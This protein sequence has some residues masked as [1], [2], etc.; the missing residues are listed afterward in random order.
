MYQDF[1]G[2]TNYFWVCGRNFECIYQSIL[3]IEYFLRM[4]TFFEALR[5]KRSAK[6]LSQQAVAKELG[7]SD[8]TYQN[9]ETDKIPPHESLIQLNQY[10]KHDFSRYIYQDTFGTEEKSPDDPLLKEL[11]ALVAKYSNVNSDDPRKKFQQALQSGRGRKRLPEERSRPSDD[12]LKVQGHLR[13]RGNKG[14]KGK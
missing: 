2:I 6:N 11:Q 9:W 13:G 7:V 14:S 8:T 10:Y 5:E 3:G 12:K 4:K 1:I